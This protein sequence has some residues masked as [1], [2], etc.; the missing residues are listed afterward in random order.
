MPR[1]ISRNEAAVMIGE[2]MYGKPQSLSLAKLIELV[3]NGQIRQLS[4]PSLGGKLQRHLIDADS[5]E[6]YVRRLLEEREDGSPR[7]DAAAVAR[8]S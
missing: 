5:V 4:T 2:A 3:A 6:D 1:Y 7:E 8:A